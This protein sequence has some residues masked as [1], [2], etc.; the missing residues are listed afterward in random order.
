M[1]DTVTQ[2][3]Q[4][5]IEELLAEKKKDTK[6]AGKWGSMT[7]KDWGTISSNMRFLLSRFKDLP[8]HTCFIAQEKVSSTDEMEDIEG[9][10][11]PEVGPRTMGSVAAEMN[12]NASII[13]STFIRID[14]K[15]TKERLRGKPVIEETTQ[16]C[17]RLSPSPVYVTK[18]RTLKENEVPEYIVD[19][20]FFKLKKAMKG[21]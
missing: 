19:P 2:L 8:I 9:L 4:M 15:K 21:I 10:I 14:R 11:L 1:I 7:L 12:A 18:I 3:Q 13:G 17:M 5:M 6:E 20:T 16:F